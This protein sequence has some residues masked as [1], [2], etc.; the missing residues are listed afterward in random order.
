MTDYA[1]Y[2]HQ[3]VVGKA[4]PIS[5]EPPKP[6]P[7]G[8][9]ASRPVQEIVHSYKPAGVWI[10][11]RWDYED[12]C[13]VRGVYSSK[14]LA[15]KSFSLDK[16]DSEQYSIDDTNPDDIFIAFDGWEDHSIT[17]WRVDD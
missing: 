3:R 1:D 14:E 2:G 13:S 16:L 10:V 11:Y 7:G 15:L 9:A 12:S 6:P 4:S 17:K 8:G 5:Q